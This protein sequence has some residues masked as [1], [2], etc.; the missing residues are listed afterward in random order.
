MVVR[1]RTMFEDLM[2]DHQ[3]FETFVVTSAQ[4]QYENVS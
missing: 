2:E 3:I 4:A 1:L